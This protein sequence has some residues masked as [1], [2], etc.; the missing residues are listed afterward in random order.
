[1]RVWLR[2]GGRP[3]N[4]RQGRRNKERKERKESLEA[5]L[6]ARPVPAAYLYFCHFEFRFELSHFLLPSP[7]SLVATQPQLNLGRTGVDKHIAGASRP[8]QPP[9]RTKIWGPLLLS[10][11]PQPL[12]EL[13]TVNS[14]Q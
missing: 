11:G 6:V 14:T 12:L 7:R 1:M 13:D 3:G 8:I 2:C 10:P 9:K 4:V 5:D